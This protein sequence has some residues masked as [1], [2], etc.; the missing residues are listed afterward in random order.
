MCRNQNVDRP[1]SPSLKPHGGVA[2]R[3]VRMWRWS[4][5]DMKCEPSLSGH[6]CQLRPDSNGQSRSHG[7]GYDPATLCKAKEGVKRDGGCPSCMPAQ[8]AAKT[9]GGHESLPRRS[10]PCSPGPRPV[11][12]LAASPLGLFD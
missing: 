2:L 1:A 9:G 8:R 3:G 12:L 7:V 4:E 6:I 11:I 5:G 10:T